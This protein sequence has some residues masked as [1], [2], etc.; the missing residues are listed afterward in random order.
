MPGLA[1]Y[2]YLIPIILEDQ[3]GP[4]ANDLP[5]LLLFLLVLFLLLFKQVDDAY[6][7]DRIHRGA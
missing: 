5:V 1:F 4:L 7:K 6:D 3:Y 2:F